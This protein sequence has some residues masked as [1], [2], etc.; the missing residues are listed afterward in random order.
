MVYLC[1]Y[2]ETLARYRGLYSRSLLLVSEVSFTCIAGLFYL[3]TL[4]RY[5]GL[6][7]GDVTRAADIFFFKQK[8]FGVPW[9]GIE[10]CTRGT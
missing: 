7:K 1:V 10:A 9:R 3:N 6:Y 4:A 8:K 5:R 2:R